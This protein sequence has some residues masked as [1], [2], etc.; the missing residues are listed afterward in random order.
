LRPH[1]FILYNSVIFDE[2]SADLSPK[3]LNTF[4]VMIGKKGIFVAKA[5]RAGG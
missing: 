5:R 1:F 2:P 3:A 4:R